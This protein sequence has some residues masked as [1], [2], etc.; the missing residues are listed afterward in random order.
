MA[1][2]M[3]ELEAWSELLTS[4]LPGR[5]GGVGGDKLVSFLFFLHSVVRILASPIKV[6]GHKLLLLLYLP[7]RL[8]HIAPRFFNCV[9]FCNEL[10]LTTRILAFWDTAPL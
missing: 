8:V 1:A 7:H 3:F 6:S 2:E 4:S 10:H 5:K 9:P